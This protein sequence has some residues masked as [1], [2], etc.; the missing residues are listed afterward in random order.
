[1]KGLP[2]QITA[3]EYVI[4]LYELKLCLRDDLETDTFWIKVVDKS[5]L[6]SFKYL[7]PQIIWK[8]PGLPNGS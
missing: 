7:T 6:L 8:E 4:K 5:G 2:L 3:G 1:M